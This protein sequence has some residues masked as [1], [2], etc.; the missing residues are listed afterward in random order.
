[1]DWIEVDNDRIW[2]SHG[3]SGLS[4]LDKSTG[5]WESVPSNK[6]RGRV[7]ELI[8]GDKSVWIIADM[9]GRDN[10]IIRYDKVSDEWTMVSREDIRDLVEEILV[11]TGRIANRSNDSVGFKNNTLVFVPVCGLKVFPSNPTTAKILAFSSK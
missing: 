10:G 6:I 2:V 4:Y 5:K 9:P 8:T 7:Q 11:C 3:N 1:M